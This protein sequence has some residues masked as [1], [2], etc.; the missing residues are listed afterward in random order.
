M[1]DVYE[2]VVLGAL[3]R[4][5]QEAAAPAPEVVS[6]VENF[7]RRRARDLGYLAEARGP[8]HAPSLRVR[9]NEQLKH[10]LGNCLLVGLHLRQCVV[11]VFGERAEESPG[12]LV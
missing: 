8:S 3:A 5:R 4:K 12:G 10:A 7:P 1:R 11:G 2:R 9:I 6:Y